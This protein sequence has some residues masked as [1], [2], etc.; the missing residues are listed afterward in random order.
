MKNRNTK[1]LYFFHSH[2]ATFLLCGTDCLALLCSKLYLAGFIFEDI[3]FSYLT[4]RLVRVVNTPASY[5]GG[6]GFKYRPGDRQ[7]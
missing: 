1:R 7:S 4:E 3:H 6:P 2:H 5:S